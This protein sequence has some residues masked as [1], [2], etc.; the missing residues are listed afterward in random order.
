MNNVL[1][2]FSIDAFMNDD[3]KVEVPNPTMKCN[4]TFYSCV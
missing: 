2:R 3:H 4:K 1:I